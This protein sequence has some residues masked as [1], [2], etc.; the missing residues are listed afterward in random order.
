MVKLFS[1][2]ENSDLELDSSGNLK[3]ETDLEGLRQKVVSRLRFFQTE[4]FLN[5][6]LGVPYLQQILIKGTGAGKVAGILNTQ[7]LKE[8]EVTS[9]NNVQTSV[10]RS[11]RTFSYSAT[12]SSIYGRFEVQV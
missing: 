11:E 1:Q 2:D 9:L 8:E 4:W 6:E 10:N 7:I 3:I 12:I 5:R